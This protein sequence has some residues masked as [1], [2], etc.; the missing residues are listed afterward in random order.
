M[1]IDLNAD[2]GESFG[3]WTLGADEA[4]CQTVTSISIACGFH[5][6]DPVV[7]RET[8]RLARRTGVSIGAHP[9][10]PDRQGFGRRA[11]RMPAREIETMVLYQVS[12]V[13]GMAQAEGLRLRHVKPHGALFHHVMH[14]DDAADAFV[15]A[16]AAT[17]SERSLIGHGG[18]AL[19]RAAGR[20]GVRFV[21][22]AYMDRR[23]EAD[24]SLTSRERPDALITNPSEAAAQAVEIATHGRIRVRDRSGELIVRAE[25]LCVHSDTP[26]APEIA[27]A[28]RESLEAAGVEVAAF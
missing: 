20:L 11:M 7:L 14:D 4:L 24:G 26:G 19:E 5:A 10:Y 16:A 23:Y 6:G 18:S 9:S 25:T 2:A 17:D 27:R 21:P 8:L 3:A 15:R 1:R 22:E 13:A 12:A 28:V